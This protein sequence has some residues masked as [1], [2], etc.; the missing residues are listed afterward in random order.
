MV[1]M[2]SY[3]DASEIGDQLAIGG[4]L[5]RKKNVREFERQWSEMLRRHRIEYFHMTDCNAG[6]GPFRGKSQDEC[7]SCAREA[8][9][10]LLRHAEKGVIFSVAKRDFA[11]IVGKNGFMPNPFTLGAWYSLFH[12]RH[13]ARDKDPNCRMTYVFEAGDTHQGDAENLLRAIAQQPHRARSFHYER[14]KFLGKKASLATQAAD[15]LAWH[16]AKQADRRDRGIGRLRGD[17]KEIIEKLQIADGRHGRTLLAQLVTVTARLQDKEF[18]GRRIKPE[19]WSEY[20]RLSFLAN[21]G[22]V[23]RTM[24]RVVEMLEDPA[25]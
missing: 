12:I 6:E 24:A 10:I 17:F 23:A 14:H 1:V 21:D 16:G 3:Y 13:Y 2:V 7:D 5:F 9:K 18:A 8:I 22:N 25:A 15:I 19:F 4:L 20:V 11:E